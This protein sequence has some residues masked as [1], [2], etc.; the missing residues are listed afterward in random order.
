[1]NVFF[2]FLKGLLLFLTV[3][4]CTALIGFCFDNEMF[5]SWIVTC[6]LTTLC[7]LQLVEN[8]S[9]DK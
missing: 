6:L 4:A 9:N 5:A 2:G 1:M 7:I 8:I 3:I